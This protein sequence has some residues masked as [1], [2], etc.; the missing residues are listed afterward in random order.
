MFG[1]IKREP[2]MFD[3]VGLLDRLYR[4]QQMFDQRDVGIEGHDHSAEHGIDLS[5]SHL[6][7]G[8][9][10]RFDILDQHFEARAVHRTDLDVRPTLSNPDPSMPP[11]G[12]QSLKGIAGGVAKDLRDAQRRRYHLTRAQHVGTCSRLTFSSPTLSS[13]DASRGDDVRSQL[14]GPGGSS[15]ALGLGGHRHCAGSAR[16][17]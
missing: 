2:L 5:P 14:C 3:L 10:R 8:V 1:S 9:Q 4:L 16:R 6:F 7:D 15:A 11:P 12:T 17:W 13:Q